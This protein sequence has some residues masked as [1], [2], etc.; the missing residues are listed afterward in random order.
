LFRG[1]DA[2]RVHGEESKQGLLLA[3]RHS[4]VPIVRITDF[5]STEKPNP[6]NDDGIGILTARS[7]VSKRAGAS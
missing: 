6:H 3:R 5:K 7:A 1:D 2:T 4:N